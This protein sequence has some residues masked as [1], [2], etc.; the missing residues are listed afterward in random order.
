MGAFCEKTA[1]AFFDTAMATALKCVNLSKNRVS[2][3]ILKVE[4]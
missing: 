1:M 4:N 3:A 2:P